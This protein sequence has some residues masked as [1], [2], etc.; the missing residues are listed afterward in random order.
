MSYVIFSFEI[1]KKYVFIYQVF[2]S[3][4]KEKLGKN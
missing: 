1:Q 3:H 4:M 2:L